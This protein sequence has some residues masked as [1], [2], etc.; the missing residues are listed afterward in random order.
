MTAPEFANL[1]FISNLRKAGEIYRVPDEEDYHAVSF[2]Q[3][4]SGTDLV[5]VRTFHPDRGRYVLLLTDSHSADDQRDVVRVV[6]LSHSSDEFKY[7]ITIK[8][9]HFTDPSIRGSSYAALRVCQGMCIGWMRDRVGVMDPKDPCFLMIRMAL[10]DMY[11]LD[12]F[13]PKPMFGFE[14]GE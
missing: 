2:P 6:P 13:V 5:P 14:N 10:V 4:Y 9:S 7:V 8:N 1:P 12:D 3:Y 11:S